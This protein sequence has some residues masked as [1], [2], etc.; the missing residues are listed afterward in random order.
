[1]CRKIITFLIG[2][3][4]METQTRNTTKKVLARLLT[5]LMITSLI[6]SMFPAMAFA[7]TANNA[8]YTSNT[9][10]TSMIA[11]QSY[12]VK[13]TVKNTGAATWTA[14]AGY[15]LVAVGGSDPFASAKSYALSPSDSIKP[16]GT[17]V[18]TIAMTAPLRAGTQKT[19]W[20]MYKGTT[21]FGKVF[22]KS[23]KVTI[24]ANNSRFVSSTAPGNME[25]S[26]TVIANITFKNI[27]SNKWTAKGGYK[28]VAIGYDN[29]VFEFSG[30]YPV[31]SRD[32]IA[33][34]S[35]KTFQV[36]LD[37][38]FITE[39]LINN[40]SFSPETYTLKWQ[41]YAG[42]VKFGEV[43]STTVTVYYT[44]NQKVAI[45]TSEVSIAEQIHSQDVLDF[46]Q[47][48][49]D[50]LASG[51]DKTLLQMRIDDERELIDAINSYVGM[52]TAA[53]AAV[54]KAEGSLLQSDLDAARIVVDKLPENA[55]K[56]ALGTRLDNVQVSI[57]INMATAAVVTAEGSDLQSD[58][59]AART[60]VNALP[61]CA[62]KTSLA[63]RLDAVQAIINL[64]AAKVAAHSDLA[65]AFGAYD[66]GDYSVAN[67]SDLTAAKDAGDT[68]I[69]A[70]TSVADVTTAESAAEAAMDAVLT[71]AEED[72]AAL[73]AAKV[74]A[75]SDLATAF[76]AYDSGDYS[77]AN[78]S[79][80]TAAKD[81]GDTAIDAATSVA[82]VTTAES[83]AEA[84]MDAILTLVE[85]GI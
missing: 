34:G 40:N 53:R 69:D 73:A 50:Q 41:L 77:L 67:W 79:D 19:D 64:A 66:S 17:K 37:A 16:N 5:V 78:W 1:M 13:I 14:A 30:V 25:I 52:V 58:V 56:T 20:Q 18:F 23:V 61:A 36:E 29:E 26:S 4:F 71:Q 49:V 22:A 80:L 24:S 6:V 27:G 75:H 74:A 83:A 60:L 3:S 51:A 76:G 11:G 28:L 54:V 45:A 15:K 59:N 38:P 63:S 7:A 55:L 68:A 48:L 33:L 81:A 84:A 21:K 2:G 12:T 62:A 35:S 10:P 46:A 65:T 70:A 44:E 82:D 31:N 42:N 85:E 8:S 43:Y 57:D 47:D 39:G 72:A 32:S 9:I